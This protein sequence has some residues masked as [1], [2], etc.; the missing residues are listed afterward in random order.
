M[1]PSD[2]AI[3]EVHEIVRR[4][5]AEDPSLAATL[6]EFFQNSDASQTLHAIFVDDQDPAIIADD[7]YR[8][9]RDLCRK[10]RRIRLPPQRLFWISIGILTELASA[11]DTQAANVPDSANSGGAA[12]N[13]SKAGTKGN[14][15]MEPPKPERLDVAKL[16]DL[17][18]L[19]DAVSAV[20]KRRRISLDPANRLQEQKVFDKR[21]FSLEFARRKP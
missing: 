3:Q 7:R 2:V 8:H 12:V 5:S 10:L 4:K 15:E 14:H 6:A 21:G 20:V 18:S 17:P 1:A 9:L 16:L 11:I 13:D 19:R